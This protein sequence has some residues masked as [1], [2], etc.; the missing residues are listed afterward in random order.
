[1]K[2]KYQKVQHVNV[3]SEDAGRRIDNF[4]FRHLKQVPKTRIYRMLRKGEVRLNGH[5]VR[6]DHKLNSGD[7]VRIPPARVDESSSGQPPAYLVRRI[8]DSVIH[9][10]GLFIAINKPAGISVHSGSRDPHGVIEALRYARPD[11]KNLQLV[12]R[13][14]RMTS[15]C[16]LFCKRTDTLRLIHRVM[17]DG[18]VSK[19][20]LALVKGKPARR[21]FRVDAA[22]S[23]GHLKSGE[24]MVEV[25]RDGKQAQSVFRVVRQFGRAALAEVELLTGRTHQIR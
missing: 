23:K 20:Y 7:I 16:L 6:Q 12:H 13:L 10:D 15:G 22:L 1:M 8:E 11:E 4:L 5:R 24:R 21:E 25:S 14:D 9:E 2:E 19:K 18:Q 17:R 3:S